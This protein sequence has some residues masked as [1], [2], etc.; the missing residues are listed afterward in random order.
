[1]YNI[2]LKVR[3]GKIRPEINLKSE[4]FVSQSLGDICSLR[5]VYYLGDGRLRIGTNVEQTL[6]ASFGYIYGFDENG[7]FFIYRDR[8]GTFPLFMFEDVKNH[9]LVFFNR[10]YL[11]KEYWRDLV[12]DEVGFWETLSYESTL[13]THSLFANVVQ[14]LCASVVKIKPDLQFETKRY[15]HINYQINTALEK[16]EFFRQS[17][18]RFDYV[19]SQLD[20]NK[21]YL[22]PISGGEDSRMMA[23][24]ISKY[25][26]RE[27]VRAV[28]YGYDSRLLE[29]T[30]A[31]KV[32]SALNFDLPVF[33]KLTH[34]SYARNLTAFAELAG[35]CISIQ[36]SHLFDYIRNADVFSNLDILSCSAYSD[37]ILGFDAIASDAK[38]E[39]FVDCEYLHI[40]QKWQKSI[41]I[42]SDIVEG[43]ESDLQN[44]YSEWKD[45]SSISSIDEYIYL[46]ERN[47]KFHLL[48]ADIARDFAE[49]FLPFAQPELVDYYLSLPNKYRFRKLG[50]INML[51]KYFP[52]ISS[53]K[54]IGSLFGKEGFARPLRFTHFKLINFLNYLS[55]TYLADKI[56]VVNPYHTEN[57][58][59][60]LR[61]YHRGLLESAVDFLNANNLKGV[62]T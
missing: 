10:Y 16:E 49:V 3:V 58:G 12:A 32:M 56:T 24:F 47:N 39:T 27:Q 4:G 33:H 54:S 45:N 23:A 15:W 40:L 31:K 14:V 35:G 30:Y 19:Y 20:R 13:G 9:Q 2:L 17:Y 26:P 11:I 22:L 53:I 25:I 37:G 46:V 42:P 6:N 59:Y 18:E 60:N 50:T 8:L 61:T 5:D 28:T 43:I 62:S 36:N 34:N 44:L 38:N 55:T 41:K 51:R 7:C 29:Y 52:A 1:M 57:H 21:R 48:L